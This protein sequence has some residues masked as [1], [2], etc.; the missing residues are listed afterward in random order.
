M[1]LNNPQHTSYTTAFGPSTNEVLWDNSTGGITYSSP[2]IA[3]GNVFIGADEAMNCY[4]ENNGTLAWRTYTI[5]PVTGTFGVACSPAYSNGYIYFGGDR[6]YCLYA[7][8]GT[9][10]WRVDDPGNYK[11]GDG[12][13]TV[14][15]SKVFIGGSDRKLYCIDQY[16]GDVL[17]TFQTSSSGSD[18]WG[19]YAAPAVSNGHVFLAACDGYLYQINETQ[20][21]SIATANNTFNMAYASYFSPLVVNGRVYVGCGYETANTVNRLYCLYESNLTKIWEFYPGYPICF[22]CSAGYYNG[23]IY[24]GSI[25]NSNSG[26]LFCLDATGSGGTTTITWQY[27]I[28][29][30][31]STPA[32]TNNRLYIGSK[33]NHVYCFNLSQTPDSEDFLWQFDTQGDVDS[34]CGISDGKVYVG[35]HGNGGRLYCFGSSFVPTPGSFTTLKQGWNLVSVPWVQTD[36]DID[37]VLASIGGY[38]DAVQW[39]DITDTNDPWKHH[40]VGKPFGND[41]SYI[42]EIMGF[43]IHIT[44]PGDTIFLYNGTQPTS[45]QTITLHPGWN[46]I[47][48]PSLTNY[49][50]TVGLNKLTFGTHVDSIWTYIAATQEWEEIGPSDYFEIGRGYWVYAKVKCTWEVPL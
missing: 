10:K 50:R 45:N 24:V 41:L 36:Q 38:Y 47:G 8:N 6:I 12:S 25:N 13:P 7:N 15:N 33:D 17:W 2:C 37:K 9:I 28:H 32:I 1:H 44:Q 30:T 5:Q 4:Y 46:L 27:N 14:A 39:Y 19:L 18:N 34:S 23:R 21:T 48:Y 26:K 29:N 11:H 35:S 20:P 49:N 40:K 3:D 43:W 16:T 22:F 42:N 31:W